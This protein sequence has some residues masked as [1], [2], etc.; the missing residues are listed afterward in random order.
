MKICL[1]QITTFPKDT[2]TDVRTYRKAGFT[3]MEMALSKLRDYLFNNSAE[4]LKSVMDAA[5]ISAVAAIGLASPEAQLLLTRGSEAVAYLEGLSEQMRISSMLGAKT[6]GIGV[7]PKNKEYKGWEKNAVINICK[8]GDLAARYGMTIGLEFM[9]LNPPAGPFLVDTLRDTIR[10]VEQA[11][12]QAV[13]YNLDL[14]HHFRGGGTV[15]EIRM[16]PVEKLVNVHLCDL[17]NM[18]KDAMDDSDRLLPG[19]GVLP[20]REI[21]EILNMKGYDGYL[22]LEL[23]NESIWQDEAQH[24]VDRCMKAMQEF[25]AI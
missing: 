11:D 14:F 7:D 6:I 19:D 2:M 1:S 18:P 25:E 13:G 24:A 21:A 12:H 20:L 22:S 3:A 10:L 16:L 23:L 15:A 8:A 5:G 17:P 9:S 4:E